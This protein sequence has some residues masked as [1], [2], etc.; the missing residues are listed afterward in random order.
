MSTPGVVP[1][2]FKMLE[3]KKSTIRKETC[4]V[5]SNMAAGSDTLELIVHESAN[6]K[7]LIQIALSDRADV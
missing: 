5:L 7:K 3:S 4:W 2:L 1:Q 6:I